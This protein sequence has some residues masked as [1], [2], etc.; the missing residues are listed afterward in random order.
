[1]PAGHIATLAEQEGFWMEIELKPGKIYREDSRSL[2]HGESTS[3][4]RS[5]WEKDLRHA[6]FKM[7]VKSDE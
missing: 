5:R 7:Q 2:L 1:M 4:L 3:T 6:P